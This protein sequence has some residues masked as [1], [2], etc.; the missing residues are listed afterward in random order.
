MANEYLEKAYWKVEEYMNDKD[1]LVYYDRE[2]LHKFEKE[3]MK[4]YG[5][6]QGREKGHKEGQQEGRNLERKTIIQNMISKGMAISEISELINISTEE[7]NNLL[8]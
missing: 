1:F 3:A 8:D 4:N 2:E 6:E 7:I 5:L